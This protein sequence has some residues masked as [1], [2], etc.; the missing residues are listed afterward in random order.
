MCRGTSLSISAITA[1]L[2]R[3]A[4]RR[5]ACSSV[6]DSAVA[7]AADNVAR[8]LGEQEADD[9]V[10]G[11]TEPETTMR[12]SSI[13]LFT[14]LECVDERGEDDDGGAVLAVVEDGATEFGA[15]AFRSR[16][17]GVPRCPRVDAL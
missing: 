14:I 10:A 17:S 2:A 6:P 16:S 8:A 4:P 1:G 5:G 7:A 12:T 11:G 3:P 13:F 9:R 15:G